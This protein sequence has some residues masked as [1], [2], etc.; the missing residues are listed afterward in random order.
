[1]LLFSKDVAK[2]D[3]GGEF[4]KK[5]NKNRNDGVNDIV[6]FW[7][8]SVK[9]LQ[10]LPGKL[11]TF[12]NITRLTSL[13]KELKQCQSLKSIATKTVKID[14]FLSRYLRNN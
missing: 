12:L 11:G 14:F 1:M 3:L 2:Q 5:T 7:K 6:V 8:W 13:R 10:P 9:K 4:A